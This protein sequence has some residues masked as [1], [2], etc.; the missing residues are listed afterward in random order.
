VKSGSE[1]VTARWKM[2][3]RVN[4]RVKEYSPEYAWFPLTALLLKLNVETVKIGS[5]DDFLRASEARSLERFSRSFRNL[6]SKDSQLSLLLRFW[7]FYQLRSL[8][9]GILDLSG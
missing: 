9:H 8:D 7:T 6:D 3:R 4:P 2:D 1:G 5:S